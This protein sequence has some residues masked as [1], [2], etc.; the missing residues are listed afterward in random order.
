MNFSTKSNGP[1]EKYKNVKNY[2]LVL[3]FLDGM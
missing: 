2:T 3:T 1:A